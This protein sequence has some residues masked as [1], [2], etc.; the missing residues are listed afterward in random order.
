MIAIAIEPTVS[1]RVQPTPRTTGMLNRYLP[2]VGQANVS[3]VT[4]E[5]ATM[6]ASS[7]TAAADTHR[8]GY[9]TGIAWIRSGARGVDAWSTR[10]GTDQPTAGLSSAVFTAPASL[11]HALRI[12]A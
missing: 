2:T 12:W 10:A 7:T 11:P 6:A 8:P 9:R 1:H 4:S 3:F 5:C